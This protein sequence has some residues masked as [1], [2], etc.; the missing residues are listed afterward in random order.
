MD[1]LAND[2]FGS[3]AS[4]TGITHGLFG[5]VVNNGDGTVTYTPPEGFGK[6]MSA[7]QPRMAVAYHYWNHR[8]L[9]FEMYESIRNTY[10]GPL[11]MANDLTVFNVTAG[12]VTARQAEVD[13]VA[14]AVIG[15]SETERVVGTPRPSP[16]WWKD[17]GIDWQNRS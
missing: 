5:T 10:D 8:D 4:V 15:P 6:I 9:E 17:A 11:T 16:P 7:V 2:S 3:G 12:A 1:V 14:G 13:W